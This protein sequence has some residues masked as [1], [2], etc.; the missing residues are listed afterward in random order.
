MTRDARP[1]LKSVCDRLDAFAHHTGRIVAWL[2]PAMAVIMFLVVML[3]YTLELGNIA[4]Q[5]VALYLHAAVVALCI[6]SALRHNAHIRVDIF[7]RNFSERTRAL[8]NIFGCLAL[9]IPVCV[10]LLVVSPGYVWRSWSILEASP[11]AGGIPLVFV[12][13]T[14]IPVMAA[15][16]LVQALSGLLRDILSIRRHTPPHDEQ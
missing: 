7:Y 11:E 15:L 10:M 16:L 6:A 5:E 13:K 4:I 8:I 9:L 14:L 1:A 12:L 2:I 3:R